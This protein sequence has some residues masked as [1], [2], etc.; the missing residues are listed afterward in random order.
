MEEKKGF[1]TRL[2]HG[3][4]EPCPQTGSLIP[5]LY[6]TSTF[7]FDN[8]EQGAKRFAGEEKGYIYSRLGNPTLTR[9][10]EALADLEEA[11]AG[12]AF[13]SGM[14]AVS[15]VLIALL[16]NGDHLLCGDTV[17]GCTYGLLRLF[18]EKFG[19]E[20]GFADL[21]APEEAVK[22]IQPN[23]RVIYLETPVN[24][25]MNLVDLEAV[26]RLARQTGAWVVVDNTFATPYLQQPLKLG[27]DFVV[28]S[29]TKYIGGHGDVIAG[30]T[31]GKRE[32]LDEIRSTTLKDIGGVLSPFDAWLLLRGLRTLA[33]RMDRHVANARE[34]V[35]FLE[36]HPAVGEV[37]YPGS[38][39]HPQNRLAN[40]Q[41]R[42]PG[43]VVGFRL[44][45]GESAARAFLDRVRLCRLTVSLGETTT[46]IQHPATMTHAVVPA[47]AREQMGITGDL[48]RISTGI[49][50]I[51]DIIADLEQALDKGSS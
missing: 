25:T 14:A 27:A 48:V 42:A 40:R 36:N 19:I 35:R 7:V 28:H 50:D 16:K 2:V 47:D 8:V 6:Q 11:E 23:T 5:P 49:E 20:V 38:P 46:L 45:G 29:A 41:M 3:G 22:A 12:L 31:L 21:S 30:I 4:G 18:Q 33:V 37:L 51:Q 32:I 10:E 13:G 1:S 44:K 24:P 39:N 15:G 26:S 43:G 34:V 9:L 17:Y